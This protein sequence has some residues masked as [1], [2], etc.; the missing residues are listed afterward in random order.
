MDAAVRERLRSIA[1]E[2]KRIQD[3]MSTQEVA[4]D[5]DQYR[6][7]AKRYRAVEDISRYFER[8]ESEEERLLQA[9]QMLRDESDEELRA[10]A[11][12]ERDMLRESL[13]TLEQEIKYLLVPKDPNDYKNTIIEIR[14]GTGG[15]EASL[16]VADLYRM[17]SR[18]AESQGWRIEV[19]SSNPTDLGGYKEISFQVNGDRVF[20]KMKW[21][22]GVHRVQRVPETEAQGRVHTSAVTVA[23]LPE[24]EEVEVE[25]HANELQID[26]YRSSGPG[27]QSVNTTDSAVRITHLPTGM[28][29]TCQ[30]EKSQLKNKVQ[31]MRVLRSRLLD[32]RQSAEDALRSDERRSQVGS[33]DRSERIRTYNFPQNRLTDHRV[34]VTLY[35]LDRVM[36][37]GSGLLEIIEALSAADREAKLAAAD[38]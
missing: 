35:S 27:G 2:A 22:G 9:E 8:Y 16:F 19:L 38:L 7:F 30:D 13:A 4:S 6:E 37:G 17:Y 20:S 11:I 24:A 25:I 34:N 36:E 15:D 28:I 21:E 5:P 23:V 14:A 12:E 1:A 26:V 33:G 31:A 10:M 29:V 32:I 18:F 3:A